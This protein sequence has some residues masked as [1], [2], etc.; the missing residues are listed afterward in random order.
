MASST[1]LYFLSSDA[2]VAHLIDGILCVIQAGEVDEGFALDTVDDA[3]TH[4]PVPGEDATQELLT[5]IVANVV[6]PHAVGR[7]A[8]AKSQLQDKLN[9]QS[10]E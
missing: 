8:L 5:D 10:S 1:H 2:S 6:H 7:H 4:L 3:V 9:V